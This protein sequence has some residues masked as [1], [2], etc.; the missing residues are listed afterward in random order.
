MRC[1]TDERYLGICETSGCRIREI[2]QDDTRAI[3]PFD[4]KRAGR[5]ASNTE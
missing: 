4:Q 1:N 2:V 3:P 5:K